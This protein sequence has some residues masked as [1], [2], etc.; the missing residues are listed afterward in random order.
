MKSIDELNQRL[1]VLDK[2]G[3]DIHQ[4]AILRVE[5]SLDFWNAPT[6]LLLALL[7][8]LKLNESTHNMRLYRGKN[9]IQFFE[10][11]DN[12]NHRRPAPNTHLE[13]VDLIEDGYTIGINHRDSP[14]AFRAYKKVTDKQGEIQLPVEQH[15]LRLEVNVDLKLEGSML[16]QLG[17]V[18][19]EVGKNFSFL[20]LKRSAVLDEQIEFDRFRLHGMAV[21]PFLDNSRNKRTVSPIMEPFTDLNDYVRQAIKN[22]ARKF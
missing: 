20:R 1:A 5:L 11:R 17:K 13:L 18:I 14:L 3:F 4:T 6:P 12:E 22:L 21:T 8:S 19:Q 16:P 9:D 7:K 10:I 2:H 15:R